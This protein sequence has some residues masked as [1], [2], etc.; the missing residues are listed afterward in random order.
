MVLKL[1]PAEHHSVKPYIQTHHVE[2]TGLQSLENRKSTFQN[3]CN[4][5]ENKIDCN[6]YICLLEG[7]VSLYF[8]PYS[9]FIAIAINMLEY[10]VADR[11]ISTEG[12]FFIFCLHFPGRHPCTRFLYEILTWC[13]QGS[14][15]ISGTQLSLSFQTSFQSNIIF[16]FFPAV[17]IATLTQRCLGFEH[18]DKRKQSTLALLD[19]TIWIRLKLTS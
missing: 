11:K 16:L 15:L 14:C 9:V 3:C 1:N 5:D 6:R 10:N 12:C 2:Y 7:G 18:E 4:K 17:Y 13:R 8:F 19:H